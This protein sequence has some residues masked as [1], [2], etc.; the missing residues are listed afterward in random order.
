V[1][2]PSDAN[3]ASLKSVKLSKNTI[4]RAIASTVATHGTLMAFGLK[5]VPGASDP[6]A[7]GGPPSSKTTGG[8]SSSKS[9]GGASGFKVTGG[10]L[11]SKGAAGSRK[12]IMPVKKRRVPPIGPMAGVSLEEFQDSSPRDQTIRT[13][14]PEILL[15][16]EPHGQSP[17]S[18]VIRP[19]P[20][21]VLQ[22]TTPFGV[23]APL[24]VF[25][26]SL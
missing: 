22:T 13:V 25:T 17:P 1:K 10:G 21:V 5:T 8:T 6:V 23:G 20:P 19:N 2:G 18:S 11:V 9:V 4:P 24:Q 3:V 16:S 12:A 7:A 15:R 14:V 26:D